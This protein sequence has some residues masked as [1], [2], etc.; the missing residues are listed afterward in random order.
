MP[1]RTFYCLLF[2]VAATEANACSIEGAWTFSA[3][4]DSVGEE[5]GQ[6]RPISDER[7]VLEVSQGCT[8]RLLYYGDNEAAEQTCR[9]YEQ[10]DVI[11]VCSVESTTAD[12]WI[13]DSFRLTNAGDKLVGH[14]LHLMTP[15][16]FDN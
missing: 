7:G 4:S 12:S 10:K 13:P 9:I 6:S 16:E 11:V 15:V 8:G 1:F 3:R 2:I 5:G 14:S